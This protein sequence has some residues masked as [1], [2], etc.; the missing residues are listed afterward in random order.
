MTDCWKS[1]QI[2]SPVA[3]SLVYFLE[4]NFI[5]NDLDQSINASMLEK[6]F[7]FDSKSQILENFRLRRALQ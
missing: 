6:W 1:G 3:S 4:Y 7:R 2:F 5:V